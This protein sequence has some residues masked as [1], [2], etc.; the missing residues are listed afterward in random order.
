[1]SVIMASRNSDA[2]GSEG[3]TIVDKQW[4]GFVTQIADRQFLDDVV[5]GE[6]DHSN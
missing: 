6:A 4:S 1:M 2:W 5:V 3:V